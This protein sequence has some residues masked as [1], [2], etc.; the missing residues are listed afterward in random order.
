MGIGNLLYYVYVGTV[1]TLCIVSYNIVALLLF[2][3]N[4]VLL[5]IPVSVFNY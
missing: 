5:A 1:P 2:F 3:L 4:K